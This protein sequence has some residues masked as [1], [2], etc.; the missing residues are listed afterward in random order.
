MADE[1]RQA[2]ADFVAGNV[3][4]PPFVQQ[5]DAEKIQISDD[6]LK[7]LQDRLHKLQQV[8]GETPA[9]TDDPGQFATAV[10]DREAEAQKRDDEGEPIPR[11][12]EDKPVI[13]QA[14]AAHDALVQLPHPGG[15]GVL[16]LVLALFFVI[17]IPATTAGETRGLLLWEVLLGK[18]QLTGIDSY[19]VGGNGSVE[20]GLEAVAKAGQQLA[21]GGSG[22]GG[23]SGGSKTTVADV[24]LGMP[25]FGGGMVGL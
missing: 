18:K 10:R 4:R 2:L 6:K 25:T 21:N 20:T 17:L 8:P 5:S 7:A 12:N 14:Y 15:I 9:A 16:V 3:Q 13:K 11:W 1:H 23:G 24:S 22:S 19:V